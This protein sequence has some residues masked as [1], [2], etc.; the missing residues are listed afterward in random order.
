MGTI[1]L[2]WPVAVLVGVMLLEPLGQVLEWRAT[3]ARKR[4]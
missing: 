3:R 1:L 2:W 4:K